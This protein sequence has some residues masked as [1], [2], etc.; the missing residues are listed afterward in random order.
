MVFRRVQFIGPIL[1]LIYINDLYNVSTL[2]TFI[3]FAEDTNMFM[4]DSNAS[5][6]VKVVNQELKKAGYLVQSQQTLS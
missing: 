1:F 6:L 2:M 4:S 3:I 5:H